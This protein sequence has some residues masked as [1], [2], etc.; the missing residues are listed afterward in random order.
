MASLLFLVVMPFL[1][2]MKIPMLL[3]QRR[4]LMFLIAHLS[5]ALDEMFGDWRTL[6]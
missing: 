3:Y 1:H 4:S 6:P 2:Q 5:N